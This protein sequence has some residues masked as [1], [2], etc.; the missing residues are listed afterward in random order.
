MAKMCLDWRVIAGL[1]A[2]ALGVWVL[3][4]DLVGTALPLLLLAACPLS[5]LVMVPLMMRGTRA[6]RRDAAPH[7][8]TRDSRTRDE[9]LAELKAQQDA[10]TR[11]IGRLEGTDAPVVREAEVVARAAAER[12]PDRP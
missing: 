9:R 7:Q 1:A 2:V 8:A 3:A 4:P 11:E 12:S 6:G 10:I 5:M